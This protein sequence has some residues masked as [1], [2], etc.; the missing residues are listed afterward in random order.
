MISVNSCD[1]IFLLR[2]ATGSNQGSF[3]T[4][5]SLI[6]QMHNVCLGV[7]DFTV[8]MK[9]DLLISGV[10]MVDSVFTYFLLFL[11]KI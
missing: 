3:F 2:S 4:K 9:V 7:K 1:C 6:C 10:L 8:F 11:R 5:I